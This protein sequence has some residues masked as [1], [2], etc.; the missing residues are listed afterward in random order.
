MYVCHITEILLK[1]ALNTITVTLSKTP[2]VLLVIFWKSPKSLL[3]TGRSIYG[4]KGIK[5]TSWITCYHCH[6]HFQN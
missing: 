4:R 3:V 1:V 6:I 5:S 2:I